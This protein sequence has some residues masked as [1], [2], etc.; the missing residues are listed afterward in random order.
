MTKGSW[1]PGKACW[2]GGTEGN[3]GHPEVCRS[4]ADSQPRAAPSRQQCPVQ[5]VPLA[6][7]LLCLCEKCLCFSLCL[8]VSHDPGVLL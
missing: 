8:W 3:C 5:F 6:H 7:C 4:Q 1:R 2:G